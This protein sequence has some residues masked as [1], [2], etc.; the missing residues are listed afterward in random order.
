MQIFEM[1]MPQRAISA[2]T[3]LGSYILLICF[4]FPFNLLILRKRGRLRNN[5]VGSHSSEITVQD[6]AIEMTTSKH[7]QNGRT[8]DLEVFP[9]NV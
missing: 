9:L 5:K 8:G 1:P 7:F 3:L 4:S 6:S 2:G